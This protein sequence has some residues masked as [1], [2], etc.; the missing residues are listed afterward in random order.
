MLASSAAPRATRHPP[1]ATRRVTRIQAHCLLLV[2]QL[3]VVLQVQLLHL[4]SRLFSRDSYT[5]ESH[6]SPKTLPNPIRLDA[7]RGGVP[8]AVQQPL[9]RPEVL[10]LR[11]LPQVPLQAPQLALLQLLQDATRRRQVL[12]VS[13]RV[14]ERDESSPAVCGF[15]LNICQLCQLCVGRQSYARSKCVLLSQFRLG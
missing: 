3:P 14:A 1:P 5:L 7:Q 9:E 10:G 8:G 4:A 15:G 12:S 11:G 6:P 13:R 2:R